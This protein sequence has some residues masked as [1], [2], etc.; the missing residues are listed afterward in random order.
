MPARAEALKE[1]MERARTEL[2]EM[3]VFADR[4]DEM[5]DYRQ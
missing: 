1:K 5:F 4:V 2:G 3:T